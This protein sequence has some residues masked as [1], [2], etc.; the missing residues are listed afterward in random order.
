[1]DSLPAY[2]NMPASDLKVAI[3]A[4]EPEFG[5]SLMGRWQLERSAPGFLALNA[6]PSPEVLSQCDL[7]VVEVVAAERLP[8]LLKTLDSS[9][10][11]LICVVAAGEFRQI[12]ESFPQLLLVKQD[13]SWM[14]NVIVLA[15]EYL[16]RRYAVL[17][18]QRAEQ[19]LA[20]CQRYVTLGKY[21]VEMRHNINNAL[22]S[23][24]GNAELLLL[25]SHSFSGEAHDQLETI[26]CT[27]LRLHEIMQRFWSLEAE[28]QV[29]ERNSSV[30]E[31]RPGVVEQPQ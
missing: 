13:E 9:E 28:M 15:G 25:D 4:D 23:V 26:R 17:R 27:S 11:P 31:D 5:R 1:M 19:A 7:T 20:A 29:A 18:A 16:R 14:E 22:T 6:N 2:M 24:L 8:Q 10:R 21:V 12:H 30:A 3:V